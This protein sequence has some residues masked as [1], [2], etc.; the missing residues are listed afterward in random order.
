MGM[1]GLYLIHCVFLGWAYALIRWNM[2]LTDSA[3]S[4]KNSN[5]LYGAQEY[6]G[7]RIDRLSAPGRSSNVK[8]TITQFTARQVP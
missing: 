3:V 1:I 5:L 8:A 6:H 4:G 7:W 2:C